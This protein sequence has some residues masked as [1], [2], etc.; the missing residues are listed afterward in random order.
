MNRSRMH[1]PVMVLVLATL[2]ACETEAEREA[3][4]EWQ[5]EWDRVVA[6]DSAET[7]FDFMVS[8]GGGYRAKFIHRVKEE[9]RVAF[10]IDDTDSTFYMLEFDLAALSYLSGLTD[11]DIAV[12]VRGDLI[13][14]GYGVK[15]GGSAGVIK[16]GGTL[17]GTLEIRDRAAGE[18]LAEHD[19]SFLRRP[20]RKMLRSE[21]LLKPLLYL[22]YYQ[23]EVFLVDAFSQIAEDRMRFLFE[24]SGLPL[25]SLEVGRCARVLLLLPSM[26]EELRDP[27]TLNFVI[28]R[29]RN[30]EEPLTRH[31][32][33]LALTYSTDSL[34]IATLVEG[35]DWDSDVREHI[36]KREYRLYLETISK[37]V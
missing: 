25:K 11:A 10:H 20:P 33:T 35:R 4:R 6:I 26:A 2:S 32:A 8:Y 1:L 14:A 13:S 28:D 18:I 36:R 19:F 16:S 15:Y 3:R 12:S 29:M 21:R 17:S 5:K 23:L 37:R 34:T 9:Q 31:V 7:Y 22:Y 24:L 30:A 27:E